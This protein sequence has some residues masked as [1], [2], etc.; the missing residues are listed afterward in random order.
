MINC[1]ELSFRKIFSH[2]A[3]HQDDGKDYGELSHEY[4]L[5]CQMNFYAKQAI[6]GETKGQDSIIK[7]FPLVPTCIFLGK[8][9]LTSDKGDQLQFWAHKQ[10][11]KESFHE[12]KI[13]F[14]EFELVD[15][16]MVYLALP[17]LGDETSH[18]Y[19][20]SKWKS[21]MGNKRMP[22]MSSRHERHANISYFVTMP[23]EWM[24]CYNR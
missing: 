15:W 22:T 2:V 21:A 6:L 1:K 5:N 3:A 12:S 8:N 10:V 19:S 18:E 9:K 20:S 23:E 7:R 14:K 16:E 4:Q 17:N 24:H 11:A 13:M